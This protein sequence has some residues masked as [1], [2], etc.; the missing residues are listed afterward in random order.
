MAEATGTKLLTVIEVAERL[1]VCVRTVR[2]KIK[3]GLLRVR[4]LG[5]S[6]RVDERDLAEFVASLPR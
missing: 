5:R 3:E 4:R 1:N 2:K 6:V